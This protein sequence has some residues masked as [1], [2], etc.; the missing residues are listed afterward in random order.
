MF[1][2]LGDGFKESIKI[3]LSLIYSGVRMLVFLL[4]N[5]NYAVPVPPCIT[6]SWAILLEI[7]FVVLFL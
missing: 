1:T 7:F 2:K 3:N 5:A 4:A 6:R